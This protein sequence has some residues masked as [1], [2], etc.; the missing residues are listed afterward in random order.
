L[1]FLMLFYV[2]CVFHKLYRFCTCSNLAL[3]TE[4]YMGIYRYKKY[5]IVVHLINLICS[6]LLIYDSMYKNVRNVQVRVVLVLRNLICSA[7]LIYDSMYKNVR[8]VQVRVV[9]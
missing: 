8:N 1:S 7:L 9:Y 3:R 2:F 6:A 4:K 5:F